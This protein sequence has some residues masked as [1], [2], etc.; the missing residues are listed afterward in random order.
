MESLGCQYAL[1]LDGGGSSTLW[2]KDKVMNQTFGDTD[3]GNGLQ[4]VR[5]VSDAIIFKRR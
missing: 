5:A 4:T 3:E 1:N 2:V